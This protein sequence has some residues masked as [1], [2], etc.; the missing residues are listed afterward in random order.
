MAE[1][2]TP[3]YRLLEAA[4]NNI[5]IREYPS[6][7]LAEVEVS[8]ARNEAA[9]KAFNILAAFIF[10]E[11]TPQEKIDMTSPVTQARSEK[12][13]MTAPVTQ[14]SSDDGKWTVA[15]IMPAAYTMETL[16]KPKDAR[17]VIRETST[18]KAVAIRFSGRMTDSNMN[19]HKSMLD[20]FIE[21]TGLK[22]DGSAI[23][24]YYDGPFTPFF[25]RRNEVMYY[26]A[27]DASS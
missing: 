19:K 1:T 8:G 21:E 5:E 25:L 15:F 26:L 3:D 22:T 2:E 16:P 27:A 18:R 4:P 23:Y 11:N 6:L 14:E 12:I 20:D 17:I 7:L 24:A 10:G 9:N 13:A